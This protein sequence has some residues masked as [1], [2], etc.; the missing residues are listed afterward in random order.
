MA[1]GDV[2]DCTGRFQSALP[3]GWFVGL[4]PILSGLIAGFATTFSYIYSLYA[5]AKNQTRILT[6]TGG[7]LDLISADFFGTALPRLPGEY[8]A[9]FL[10][11]IQANLFLPRVSRPAMVSVLTALTGKAPVIFEPMNPV[12]TGAMGVKT[13]SA[14]CGI[15]RYGSIAMP[16]TAFIEAFLP[17]SAG[18]IAG[19]GFCNAATLSA[20]NTPLS[21]GY[22][23]SLATYESTIGATA[24]YA[25]INATRP[26]ASVMGVDLINGTAPTQD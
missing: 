8:D 6:A 12:D 19:A 24:I 25:A 17:Q 15:A 16:F 9:S 14:Y 26:A 3:R 4:T 10:T 23:A 18:Q 22:T 21:Q 2:N 5:Y 7:W 1:I 13:S 11:R 20:M